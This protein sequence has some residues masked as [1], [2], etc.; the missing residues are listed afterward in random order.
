MKRNLLAGT[1]L[2]R[3]TFPKLFRNLTHYFFG[4]DLGSAG[5]PSFGGIGLFYNLDTPGKG[6]DTRGTL[7]LNLS[8]KIPFS[9]YSG[10]RIGVN[11]GWIQRRFDGSF[12]ADQIAHLNSLY[13][14]IYQPIYDPPDNDVVN[15]F[16]AGAG[17][18]FQFSTPSGKLLG[19]FGFGTGHL[20]R[21]DLSFSKSDNA[22][23]PVRWVLHGE[24]AVDLSSGE[25]A[26]RSLWDHGF[27]IYPGFY[28]QRQGEQNF[29][30]A[31]I[32]FTKL[33]IYTGAWYRSWFMNGSHTD[34][35]LLTLGYCFYFPNGMSIKPNY[36][37]EIQLNNM[38]SGT[39]GIHEFS[40]VFGVEGLRVVLGK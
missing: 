10:L 17:L 7:G 39:G 5:L 11:L 4:L 12:F 16:D 22:Q 32:N 31:G 19:D 2:M 30:E 3:D 20:F 27:W 8:G 36:S 33:N 28:Y 34:G 29:L 37:Y 40:M 18:L 24:L 9:P 14:W 13:G 6:W 15:R 23:Y 38:N 26:H 1:F 35:F 21:P 25:V